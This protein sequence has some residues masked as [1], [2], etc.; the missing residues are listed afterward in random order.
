MSLVTPFR[1]P[2]AIPK[3]FGAYRPMK[4]ITEMQKRL[5]VLN[6]WKYLLQA[7]PNKLKEPA[8]MCLSLSMLSP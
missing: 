3:V 5:R 6:N 1:L 4:M 2:I 7:H 8:D